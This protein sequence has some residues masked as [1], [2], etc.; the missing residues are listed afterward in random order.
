M[1]GFFCDT[2]V[3]ER[4]SKAFFSFAFSLRSFFIGRKKVCAKRENTHKTNFFSLFSSLSSFLRESQKNFYFPPQ[5]GREKRDIKTENTKA[6]EKRCPF[7]PPPPLPPPREKRCSDS[8]RGRPSFFLTLLLA[9]EQR[10]QMGCFLRTTTRG[11]F[12]YHS[13]RRRVR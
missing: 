2:L 8:S 1:I 9:G 13:S 5:T 10:E 7:P 11:D 4:S 3:F 6:Q 12:F